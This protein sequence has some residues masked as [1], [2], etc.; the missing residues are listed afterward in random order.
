MVYTEIQVKR[1]KKYYYR[2]HTVREKGKFKK[3]RIYLGKGLG[4]D[5]LI[6][7]ELEADVEIR[8]KCGEA[9]NSKIS[10]RKLYKQSGAGFAI[11][12]GLPMYVINFP[13]EFESGLVTGF[14]EDMCYSSPDNQ[15]FHY[16]SFEK[17]VPVVK[18]MFKRME[19]NPLWVEGHLNEFNAAVKGLEALGEKLIVSAHN[20]SKDKKEDVLNVYERFLEK[21]MDYW[22]PSVFIDLFDPFEKEVIEF[23]FQEKKEKM[24]KEDL[25][26][27]FLPDKS[28]YWEEKQEFEKIK[29]YVRKN[30]IAKSDKRLWKKLAAHAEKFWW[31]RN[32]YQNVL[33]LG[34]SDFAAQL[35]NSFEKQFWTDIPETKKK[36]ISKYDLDKKTVQR[37]RQFSKMA[38]F[39]DI[40]KQ[41]TQITSYFIVEFYHIIAKKQGIPVEWSNFVIPFYEY[42][43]FLK[44]DSKLLKE[45]ELRTKKGVWVISKDD[46]GKFKIETKKADK[47]FE[48]VENKISGGDILYGSTAY[49]GIA[50]GKAKVILRQLDFSKFNEGD[51]LI[52]GMTRPEFVPLMKKAAAVVTDEGGITCHAAIISRELGLPCVTGTQRATKTYKDGDILE[53]NANHGFVRR[54]LK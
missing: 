39:R 47:L 43:K 25:Q 22:I 23:V 10:Q 45:L 34:A 31:M 50:S 16:F 15:F 48:L 36:L 42:R 29:E 38:Y 51:I 20:F 35:E 27:L 21:V 5:E 53:V 12:I 54:G 40:R 24:K 30:S 11:C 13:I 9:H 28:I 33:K 18:E 52:T 6:D 14:P 3:F 17:T 7:R 26:Y 49:M 2:T 46:Y 4:K 44:K 1:G 37:I 32:D 8:K 41:Y 19:E